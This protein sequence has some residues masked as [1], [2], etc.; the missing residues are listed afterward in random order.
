MGLSN[1]RIQ[2][3]TLLVMSIR[4]MVVMSLS[5]AF[6]GRAVPARLKLAC[7]VALGALMRPAFDSAVWVSIG[8]NQWLGMAL[9]ECLVGGAIGFGSAVVFYGIEMSGLCVD[10]FRGQTIVQVFVPQS[11]DRASQLGQMF[12]MLAACLF[13]TTHAY[14]PFLAALHRSYLEFPVG[15]GFPIGLFNGTIDWTRW[16]KITAHSFEIALVLSAPV[17]GVLLVTD[18]LL[19]FLN[20]LVPGLQVFDMGL[21]LKILLGIFLTA[22]VMDRIVSG[23]IEEVA[24][25]HA[26]ELRC[27]IDKTP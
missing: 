1:L 22:L 14:I 21:G 11:G 13:F 7:A 26:G 9:N 3:L 25:G 12:L 10:L 20:R 5:P 17:I 8:M 6:G 15:F 4:I 24:V 19:G 23:V 27:W 2:L 16:L 18:W